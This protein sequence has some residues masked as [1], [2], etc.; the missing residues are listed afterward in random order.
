MLRY[1][2][3][4]FEHEKEVTMA[5]LCRSKAFCQAAQEM[6]EPQGGLPQVGGRLHAPPKCVNGTRG[7]VS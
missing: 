1:N 6:G 3:G 4:R 2:L 5:A 7:K